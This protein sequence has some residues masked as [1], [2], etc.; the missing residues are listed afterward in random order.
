[1]KLS[2]LF[3]SLIETFLLSREHFHLEF[4]LYPCRPSKSKS[5]VVVPRTSSGREKDGQK[6]KYGKNSGKPAITFAAIL[7]IFV[8]VAL[9]M[10]RCHALQLSYLFTHLLNATAATDCSINKFIQPAVAAIVSRHGPMFIYHSA[11][12][13]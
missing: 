11:R 2:T 6:A 13:R 1:M 5:S 9:L 7:A 3:D 10:V 4:V 8:H 12:N